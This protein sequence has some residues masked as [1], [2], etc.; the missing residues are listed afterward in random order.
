MKA[1]TYPG[2]I[3]IAL[4]VVL[5]SLPDTGQEQLGVRRLHAQLVPEADSQRRPMPQLSLP[6]Q[7]ANQGVRL[8]ELHVDVKVVGNLATTTMKM[9]FHNDLLQV[10]E[11]E[12]QFPLGE[13]QTVSRFAMS[14]GK[15]IRE[16]VIVEKV[17]GRKTFETIVRRGVDPG[18]LEK[19]AGNVFRAR[20]FPIP[21]RGDKTIVVAY[22]QELRAA[23]DRWNYLLPLMFGAPVERFS[24]RVEVL[25]Q[26]LPPSLNDNQLRNFLF[27]R[28]DDN[29]VG[30]VE[31]RNYV[32]DEALAFALPF[33]EHVPQLLLEEVAGDCYFWLNLYPPFEPRPQTRAQRLSLVWDASL[34]AGQRD[35]R[36]DLA[37]LDRYLTALGDCD[38][39]VFFLRNDI[40]SV[41]RFPVRK[42]DWRLLKQKLLDTPL[43]GGSNLGALNLNKDDCDV[44]LLFSDG[45]AT[46]GK[47]SITPGE[48][49][50]MIINSSPMANHSLLRFV[51]QQTGGRYLNLV[52]VDLDEA[53]A[54]LLN[55]PFR[56]TKMVYDGAE[57]SELYAGRLT[58]QRNFTL[59]GKLTAEA[60]ELHLGFGYGKRTSHKEQILL[61]RRH[62]TNFGAVLP[63]IWAQQKL[64]A[65]E[66]FPERNREAITSLGLRFGIVTPYTSLIVL[67]FLRDYL[68]F[69]IEPPADEPALREAYLAQIV[70]H[71]ERRHS[72]SEGFG[73]QLLRAWS[74]QQ[75]YLEQL[76]EIAGIARATQHR[77]YGAVL[78]SPP[79]LSSAKG[80]A[81]P[82]QQAAR[83][84][85][86]P[87]PEPSGPGRE[88]AENA[89]S[90]STEENR[91]KE[92]A[93]SEKLVRQ[94]SEGADESGPA[95]MVANKVL[96]SAV[97][98]EDTVED[99]S[100]EMTM[101]PS[102]SEPSNVP[103]IE[104]EI[105][106][107]PYE[108]VPVERE[109]QVDLL[110]LTRNIVYP[111]LAW[112]AGLEGIVTLRVLIDARGRPLHAQV[113]TSDSPI[114][115]QAAL[116][117]VYA[118]SFTPAIQN[119][120]PIA[121]W[122]SIPIRFRMRED[123]DRRLA[124][125]RMA[126]SS[127]PSYDFCLPLNSSVTFLRPAAHQSPVGITL[128]TADSPKERYRNYLRQRAEHVSDPHFYY[129][130]SAIFYERGEHELALRILSSILELEMENHQL[131]RM[132]GR[133]LQ[134][135]GYEEQ[136]V[137][138]FRD[139]LR[140]RE[141]EPQSNRDLALALQQQG[142]NREA[143]DHLRSVINGSWD[144]RFPDI[145]VIALRELIALDASADIGLSLPGIEAASLETPP[146]PLRIVL[147]WDSD[148]CD[149]DL[150]VEGPN[151]EL[152]YHG[153]PFPRFGGCLSRN[154]AGGYGP[155]E[156]LLAWPLPGSYTIRVRYLS[157]RQSRMAGPVTLRLRIFRDYGGPDETL[158]E[159]SLRLAKP[160][161]MLDLATIVYTPRSE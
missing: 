105:I 54:Q 102:V 143:A 127:R 136:A 93:A 147:D 14:V 108:F 48:T 140:N 6:G 148:N 107:Y 11:G 84:T 156:F 26:N 15:K 130:A 55:E 96:R 132:V 141:E 51:A 126:R 28:T 10:L 142:R 124:L 122:I 113:E 67:E 89:R 24:V 129:D 31:L 63:R 111:K 44:V 50:V 21:A 4:L 152:A 72:S 144:R 23:T 69:R 42:G 114:L 80:A 135:W 153:N 87:A 2:K 115:N 112:Y 117:A 61:E 71:D 60:A 52:G 161:R 18:L 100:G 155:E 56:L 106:P 95:D 46:I 116:D 57:V 38:V 138:I 94:A 83:V 34:S 37:L 97:G 104:E 145:A 90:Q 118:T 45:I 35:R 151:N 160:G 29:Y 149:L 75:Y 159:T 78:S 139:V 9:V 73:A 85:A 68:R 27:R 62:S 7:T 12:L 81:A 86:P 91:H 109:A 121:S 146:L 13:G 66:L 25:K 17:K 76:P 77:T 123:Y 41:G 20:V 32:P 92:F 158:H 22:E 53:A 65:L 58:L 103:P 120:R 43:D 98:N 110:E 70:R 30:S 101:L 131:L 137:G 154:F 82:L 8:R 49:P 79:P 157:N 74:L 1:R 99:W 40:E 33:S 64:A 19:T 88:E 134:E 5:I 133:R 47:K 16:G 59:A 39:D 3:G 36:R 150:M 119:D 125:E 128:H